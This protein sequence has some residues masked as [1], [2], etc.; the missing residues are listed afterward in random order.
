[1]NSITSCLLNQIV[2][3]L[4]LIVVLQYYINQLLYMANSLNIPVMSTFFDRIAYNT[5]TFLSTENSY[6]LSLNVQV[7]ENL[8]YIAGNTALCMFFK[9]MRQCEPYSKWIRQKLSLASF[10]STT[11]TKL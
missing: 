3:I 5:F 2:G 7:R 8:G 11:L 6:M 9:S 10:D 1:M 4:C